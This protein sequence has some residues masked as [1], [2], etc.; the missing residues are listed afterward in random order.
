MC[1]G[2][3][4]YFVYLVVFFDMFFFIVLIF[5]DFE[6][7]LLGCSI[8]FIGVKGGVG[9]FMIVYNVVFGIL[10][11]FVMEII[12]VDFDFVFGMVNINF[13]QDLVM[14]MLEVVYL[15]E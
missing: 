3:F 9:F 1:N 6:V 10:S 7:E 13:D 2:I 5:V 8:V 11:L 15:L 12:F 4:E 14:G